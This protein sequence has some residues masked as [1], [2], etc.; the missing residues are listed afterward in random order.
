MQLVS[1]QAANGETNQSLNRQP[2]LGRFI[3]GEE[4]VGEELY[5]IGPW[6]RSGMP[7]QADVPS[8][9]MDLR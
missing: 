9:W 5:A 1:I 6:Q 2:R 3:E 4:L 8:M 7:V